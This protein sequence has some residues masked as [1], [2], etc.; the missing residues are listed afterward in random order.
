MAYTLVDI[1]TRAATRAADT[2]FTAAEAKKFVNDTQ[3]AVANEYILRFWESAQSYTLTTNVADITNGVGLPSDF[4]SCI[5][6][7]ITTA[8]KQNVL[9]RVDFYKFQKDNPAW[10]SDAA[11]VPYC[12]YILGNT[13]SVYPKPDAA[14]TMHMRFQMRPSQLTSDAHVPT[15][16][17]EFEELLIY[18]AAYRMFEERDLDEKAA[19]FQGKYE[20]EVAKLVNR[21][22]DRQLG[23]VHYIN[24]PR[25]SRAESYI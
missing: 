7:R 17:S 16:P 3:N 23:Q 22:S 8:G 10:D 18:G 20:V 25:N 15:I 12:W 2:G 13:I 21:Y 5:A 11:G 4:V 1:A 9:D 19:L 24:T 14:Y 6:L